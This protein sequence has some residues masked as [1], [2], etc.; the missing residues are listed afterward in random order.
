M[1]LKGVVH[2]FS[3]TGLEGGYWSFQ[4]EQYIIMITD[5]KFLSKGSKVFCDALKSREGRLTRVQYLVGSKWMELPDP[6]EQDP[7]YKISTINLGEEKGDREADKRLIKTYNLAIIYSEQVMNDTYGIGNWK[8]ADNNQ[9]IITSDGEEIWGRN[10]PKVTPDRPVGQNSNFKRRVDVL[11]DDGEMEYNRP[12]T[13]LWDVRWESRG[14]E[15]LDNG[16]KLT[17]LDK[18]GKVVEW[19]GTIDHIEYPTFSEHARGLWIHTDQRG[20]E[21]KEWSDYFFN[22]H[23]AILEKRVLIKGS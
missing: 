3:E 21:R 19:S 23:P 14:L 15:R 18:E 2:F 12:T 16:D 11:W 5:P 4:N 13:Q 10:F 9:D 17:I 8:Y 22:K 7:D 1:K 20:V 6:I